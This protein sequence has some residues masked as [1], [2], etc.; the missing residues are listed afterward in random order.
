MHVDTYFSSKCFL[1]NHHFVQDAAQC[2]DVSCL[3]IWQTFAE[4]RCQV[5]R[6]SKH[7]RKLCLPAA[8]DNSNYYINVLCGNEI[9]LFEMS[10]KE[11]VVGR[12]CSMHRREVFI[13][14]LWRNLK[15]RHHTED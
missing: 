4:F 13:G 15:E 14:F 7:G 1:Q 2:P 6:S 3:V 12:V 10:V 5:A 11:G 8:C 9:P